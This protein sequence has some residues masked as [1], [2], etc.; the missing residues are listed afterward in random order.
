[1]EQSVFTPTL[2]WRYRNESLW[3]RLTAYDFSW[4][5]EF[6][7]L[8]FNWSDERAAQNLEGYRKFLYLTI[9]FEES[10]VPTDDVDLLW[11]QHILHTKRYQRDCEILFRGGFLHREIPHAGTYFTEIQK[12]FFLN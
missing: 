6:M 9:V 10:V 4:L 2:H 3:E 5:A 11:Q 12:M 7:Q 1:M 8:Q